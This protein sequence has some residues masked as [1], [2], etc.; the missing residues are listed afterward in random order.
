MCWRRRFNFMALNSF[1]FIISCFSF[2]S[3][4]RPL[5][6]VYAERGKTAN[7]SSDVSNAVCSIFFIYL[8]KKVFF[9]FSLLRVINLH[10]AHS[11]EMM[12]SCELFHF[13]YA[14]SICVDR[15]FFPFYDYLKC[16]WLTLRNSQPTSLSIKR[17][18]LHTF[19]TR[20][21]K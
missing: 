9:S 11:V 10:I 17:F 14:S 7:K 21:R 19:Q 13:L 4:H 16:R 18:I 8:K 1:F 3:S 2:L 15:N 12:C 20:T 6:S 5:T